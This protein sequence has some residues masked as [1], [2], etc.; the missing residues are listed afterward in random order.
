MEKKGV[1]FEATAAS[2]AGSYE[3]AA[4]RA[5]RKTCVPIAELTGP[6]LDWAVAQAEGVAV[7]IA[8]GNEAQHTIR[9]KGD[10][11][12]NY[13]PSTDWSQGGPLIDRH[14]IDLTDSGL[15]DR[16]A[17]VHEPHTFMVFGA[18]APTNLEAAMRAIVRM[19]AGGQET[20]CVPSE[21]V[22]ESA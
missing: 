6:A 11:S 19:H 10:A 22:Q 14:D 13:N 18:H 12:K 8:D 20:I 17:T 1:K 7:W 3:Q 4:G 21:L 9:I 5:D 2:S 15:T 16:I